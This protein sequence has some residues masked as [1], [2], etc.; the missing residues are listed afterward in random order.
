MLTSALDHYVPNPN[1]ITEAIASFFPVKTAV[2]EHFFFETGM[3][4]QQ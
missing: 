3:H 1:L 2:A 4:S